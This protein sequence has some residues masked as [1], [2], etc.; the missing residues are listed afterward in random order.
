MATWDTRE[1]ELGAQ[2]ASSSATV[3]RIHS[4]VCKDNK[5]QRPPCIS[6]ALARTPQEREESPGTWEG[7]FGA[8]PWILR[9]SGS[10][11]APLEGVKSAFNVSPV[12]LHAAPIRNRSVQRAAAGAQRG[13]A[14]LF[15]E[16][17]KYLDSLS[18]SSQVR[19]FREIKSSRKQRKP[20][21]R[22]KS[23]RP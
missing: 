12:Q 10:R 23:A 6:K 17:D 20:T 3:I 11:E 19:R 13:G 1:G 4:P 7:H 5:R 18:P 8:L 9:L 14:L 21:T 15:L 16:E 2:E 22:C